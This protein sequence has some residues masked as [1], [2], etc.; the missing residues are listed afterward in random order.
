MLEEALTSIVGTID[1]REAYNRFHYLEQRR[2]KTNS[3]T[4]QTGMP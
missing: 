3:S 2:E 4:L 1:V